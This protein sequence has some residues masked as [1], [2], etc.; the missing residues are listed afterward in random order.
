[1]YLNGL[2]NKTTNEILFY[3][4]DTFLYA[5][6]TPQNIQATQTSLQ[7]D[8]DIISKYAREW[9]ITFNPNK[10]T[11]QTFSNKKT[12]ISPKLTFQGNSIPLEDHHKHLGLI[13]SN[14]NHFH[15]HVNA[16]IKKVNIALSPLYPIARNTPRYVLNQIYTTYVLPYFDYCDSVYGAL[17]TIRDEIRLERL[18]NRTARLVTGAEFRTSTDALRRELGWDR[19]QTRRDMHKLLFFRKL[20]FEQEKFPDYITAL[21]PDTRQKDTGRILRNANAHTQIVNRT[22]SFRKSFIPDAIKRWNKLPES[23]RLQ[24]T[25]ASF[26]RALA[27]RMSM[28]K[29]TVFYNFGTR[30]GNTLHTKLRLGM[31]PLNAHQHRITKCPSPHCACGFHSE[32]TSHFTLHCPQ[33]QQHRIQ[34]FANVSKILQCDF[35]VLDPITKLD[36]LLHGKDLSASDGPKIADEYQAFVVKTGRFK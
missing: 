5:S 28:D 30:K 23:L 27:K 12:I 33:F 25:T 2:A 32:D 8:L 11:K 9:A 14:D 16:I 13:L 3:A 22:E 19:L 15:A 6:H 36:I 10:T 1:M 4:D 17:L 21:L 34:L 18:Q 24:P 35:T 31:S 7:K 26:K 29:P 20:L